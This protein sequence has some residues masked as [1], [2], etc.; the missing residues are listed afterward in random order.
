LIR[1][2]IRQSKPPEGV[3]VEDFVAMIDGRIHALARAHNQ[4]TDDHWGPAPIKS[5]LEAEA[6]AFL[7]AKRKLLKLEGPLVLLNP[8]AYSTLAL[9]I[10]ELVTNSVKYGGL[11]SET[12]EVVANWNVRDDGALDFRW[13]ERRGP[14]VMPPARKGFGSTIIE[15]SVPYDLGGTVDIRYE[16]D[17]LEV[18]FTIPARHVVQAEPREGIK[19]PEAVGDPVEPVRE[20]SAILKGKKVLLVEDSLIIAL[21]AEDLLRRLGAAKVMTESSAPGAI[22]AVEGERPDCA[23]LDIHL[24]DHT[25]APIAKRLL[26]LGV[27]FM[28]ATGYGEKN[29]LPDELRSQQVVQKPY[30]LGSLS[31]CLG[32]LLE[33]AENVA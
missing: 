10:H 2:L 28:F 19:V 29:Q 7:G 24:G 27:P 23:V 30:T 12:G 33:T 6:A 16:S 25:S 3:S 1:G 4:I 20:A 18:D 11:S 31:R 15:H 22:A 21:D 14:K 13:R 8:Q 5:L 17:G 32:E 26:E 9:V